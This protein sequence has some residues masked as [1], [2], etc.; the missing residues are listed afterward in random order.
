MYKI[1]DMVMTEVQLLEIFGL[2]AK[3]GQT[4][5]KR[6]WTNRII[7]YTFDR[8][9]FKNGASEE[10]IMAQVAARFNADMQGCLTMV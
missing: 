10:S 9:V 3:N 7:P 5:P 6:M 4:N 2:V 8:K 1:D